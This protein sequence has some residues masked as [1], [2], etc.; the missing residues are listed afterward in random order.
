M[1]REGSHVLKSS[2]YRRKEFLRLA[3]ASLMEEYVKDLL[4]K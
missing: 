3:I 2:D 4:G 1:T